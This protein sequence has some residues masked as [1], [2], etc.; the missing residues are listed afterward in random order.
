MISLQEHL[1]QLE[2]STALAEISQVLG[3]L[4]SHMEEEDRVDFLQNILG[5]AGD[6]KVG[7]MVNL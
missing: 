1:K 7:S 5:E 6:S 4:L 3:E 2:P